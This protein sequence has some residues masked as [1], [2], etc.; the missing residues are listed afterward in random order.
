ML[1]S[2]AVGAFVSVWLKARAERCRLWVDT[3]SKLRVHISWRALL[4]ATRKS[5]RVGVAPAAFEA[6]LRPAALGPSR[7]VPLT[8]VRVNSMRRWGCQEL[9][10]CSTQVGSAGVSWG[11]LGSAGVG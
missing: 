2:T 11:R 1:S 7:P 3:P 8:T 5:L 10:T 9:T 4:V 6:A